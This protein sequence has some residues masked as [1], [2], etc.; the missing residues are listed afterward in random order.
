MMMRRC[1]AIA[2]IIL[3]GSM[4]SPGAAHAQ[5]DQAELAQRIMEDGL[6]VRYGVALQVLDMGPENV[7]PVLRDALVTAFAEEAEVFRAYRRGEAPQPELSSMGML[8]LVVSE[9]R[10]QRAFEPMLATL[11][12]AMGSVRGLA[13]L[14]DPA[15]QPLVEIARAGEGP[16]DM[17]S[18]FLALRLLAEGVGQIPVSAAS[19]EE[20]IA[21]ATERLA[22]GRSLG[23]VLERAIDLAGALDDAGL[24]ETL[25]VIATD[26]T[27]VELRLASPTP[28]RVERIQQR[29]L[30][31]VRGVPPVPTWETLSAPLR[32]R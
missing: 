23:A 10:D 28:A 21:V 22:S 32:S 15:V 24:R 19:R 20:M 26:A 7:D 29:A 9:F 31:R 14:G 4:L 2:A 11:A 27:A 30:D 5:V 8:A 25:E 17:M 12:V 1:V 6:Q 16:E 13:A 18:A 3:F